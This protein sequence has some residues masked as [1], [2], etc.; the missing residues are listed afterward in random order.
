MNIKCDYNYETGFIRSY[1]KTLLL[2]ALECCLR[3]LKIINF[4]WK[5]ISNWLN[6]FFLFEI[7]WRI[8]F[9]SIKF[10]FWKTVKIFNSKES[11]EWHLMRHF[12]VVS[13]PLN[14][15]YC[16]FIADVSKTFFP[17][18]PSRINKNRTDSFTFQTNILMFIG[19][20]LI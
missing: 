4:E 16:H 10:N 13:L 2:S 3:S 20:W 11:L 18:L 14:F 7:F 12:Q 8:F 5:L 9:S 1:F 6:G 15:S 17:L 19:Y